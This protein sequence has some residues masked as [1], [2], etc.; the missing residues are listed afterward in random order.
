MA[1]DKK[2]SKGELCH[3][4][5]CC[6]ENG[7]TLECFY[8][9]EQSLSQKAGWIPSMPAEQKKYVAKTKADLIKQ[10]EKIL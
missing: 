2:E 8:E 6:A 5:I 10:L 3:I 9:A 1:E 7:Y 4:S